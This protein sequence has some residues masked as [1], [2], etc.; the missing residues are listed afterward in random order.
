MMVSKRYVHNYD[1]ESIII[2]INCCICEKAVE[3]ITDKLFNK[4][5]KR[6]YV[7]ITSEGGDMERAHAIV[8]FLRTRSCLF[9]SSNYM[10]IWR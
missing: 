9:G 8:D 4:T 6:V 10:V 2:H 1:L 7:C 3:D 5:I